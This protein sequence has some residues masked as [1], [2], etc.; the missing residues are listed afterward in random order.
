M[1]PPGDENAVAAAGAEAALREQVLRRVLSSDVLNTVKVRAHLRARLYAELKGGRRPGGSPASAGPTLQQHVLN[2]LVAEHLAASGHKYALSVFMA[3]SG[4]GGLPR[5]SRGDL[6]RLLGVLPGTQVHA[7]LALGDGGS[8]ATAGG[9]RPSPDSTSP[10]STHQ[11]SLAEAMVAALGRLGGHISTAAAACQT[12]DGAAGPAGAAATG[13]APSSQELAA[14]LSAIEEEYRRRSTQ[15]EAASAAAVE[16]RMAEFQRQCEARCVVQLAEQ[17]AALRE[18]ELTAVRAEEAERYRAQLDGERAALAAAHQERQAALH[19]QEEELLERA[20]RQ[21]RELDGLREDHLRRMRAE[22]ERLQAWKADSEA[23]AATEAAAARQQLRAAEVAAA[24]AK[25][26]AEAGERRL[27]AALEQA[28]QREA[29]AMRAQAA[30]DA[31]VRRVR[32][33]QSQLAAALEEQGALRQQL[34]AATAGHQAEQAEQRQELAALQR[35]Q[36]RLQK[37]AAATPAACLS[38]DGAGRLQA[39]VRR[40]VARADE[41]QA[42]VEAS[43]RREQLWKS[44]AAEAEKLLS[45]AAKGQDRALQHSEDLRLALAAAA[46]E[47]ADLQSQAAVAAAGL[48]GPAAAALETTSREVQR[49]QEDAEAR[50]AA[51]Q[52]AEADLRREAAQ[53]QQRALANRTGTAQGLQQ[54]SSIS[55]EASEAAAAEESESEASAAAA[56]ADGTAAT[57]GAAGA[58]EQ[59]QAAGNEPSTYSIDGFVT[60]ESSKF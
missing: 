37:A 28:Q 3:E 45:K 30:A 19:R 57:A 21:Q 1:P 4:S 23:Q 41:L 5:L 33:L 27:A 58:A 2:C 6:L 46:R 32:Q 47:V 50:V 15:Q 53:L 13:V 54:F 24:R 14:R 52:Q 43:R 17:L 26:E 10:A 7:L 38:P 35:E 39:A 12:I 36:A 25:A 9:E 29:A 59:L 20:R 31:E 18:G 48:E 49:W 11:T 56:S 42:E 22:E 8:A 16:E 51:A 55:H 60:D 34:A 40:L 44:C